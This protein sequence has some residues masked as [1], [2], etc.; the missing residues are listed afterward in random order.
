M[1]EDPIFAASDFIWEV[2]IKD[3]LTAS[4]EVQR[5]CLMFKPNQVIFKSVQGG[6][7]VILSEVIGDVPTDSQVS[8][9]SWLVGAW[10][11]APTMKMKMS[12]HKTI[13]DNSEW[14]FHSWVII[15]LKMGFGP[16]S[17]TGY[18]GHEKSTTS[19]HD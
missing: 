3:F 5:S 10:I 15:I 2:P 4:D 9:A 17:N 11:G 8:A 6:F 12:L 7:R 14:K 1:R 18:F 13:S 19:Y 16:S